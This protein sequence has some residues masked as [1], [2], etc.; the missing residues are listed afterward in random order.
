MSDEIFTALAK[1]DARIGMLEASHSELRTTLE[2]IKIASTQSRA[3]Q[4]EILTTLSGEVRLLVER[5]NVEK[6]RQEERDRHAA[7][8]EKRASARRTLLM[9]ATP[10]VLTIVAYAAIQWGESVGFRRG[11]ETQVEVELP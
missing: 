10:F 6:G 1:Q 2:Q 5:S 3:E 7:A 9:F 4:K 8:E 11:V